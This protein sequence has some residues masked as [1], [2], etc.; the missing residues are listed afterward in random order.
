MLETMSFPDIYAEAT[1][2]GIFVADWEKSSGVQDAQ[3]DVQEYETPPFHPTQSSLDPYFLTA[4]VNPDLAHQFDN[5]EADGLW[6][7][8]FTFDC[9]ATDREYNSL[10]TSP[11]TRLG[12][13]TPSSLPT[14]ISPKEQAAPVELDA[15]DPKRRNQGKRPKKVS[16][17]RPYG[18]EPLDIAPAGWDIFEYNSFG[19]LNPGQIYS[20]QELIRYLYS[21]PQHHTGETYNPK[22]DGLTLWIQRTPPD[23]ALEHG[24]PEAGLCRF[25]ACEHNNVIK[26]GDVRVAFDEL[27]KFNPNLNPQHNAG[28]VHLSCLEKNLNFPMLCKDLDVKPEG[29]VLAHMNHMILQNRSELEHV[30]RF[31]TFCNDMGRA[32]RSYSRQGL[33]IDEIMRVGGSELKPVAL[34]RWKMRGVAWD[35]ED[36]ARNQHAKAVIKNK[37]VDARARKEAVKKKRARDCDSEG[38]PEDEQGPREKIRARAFARPRG[39]KR[40][41]T[42][43]PVPKFDS[44]S[45]SS[46][47]IEFDSESEEDETPSRKRAKYALTRARR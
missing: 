30:Q 29:R 42:P 18:Y 20:A 4:P 3:L 23:L 24:H 21:N 6:N 8:F 43:T 11:L 45:D 26:A 9:Q 5:F 12:T 37:K 46:S 38:E 15:A 1:E 25:G 41:A 27:T 36:K 16:N 28:Y 14:S 35:I 33:L 44:D 39:R 47:L 32:P 2:A 17:S 7:S 19:E 34:D 10:P 40:R 22:V 31:I 13:T